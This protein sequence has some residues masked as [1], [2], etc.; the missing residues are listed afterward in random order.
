M[1]IHNNKARHA[2]EQALAYISKQ[3]TVFAD[4]DG[5]ACREVL[6]LTIRVPAKGDIAEPI[7]ILHSSG[8]F[9]YPPLEE[10]ERVMLTK[11]EIPGLYYTYGAR[12][13][14]HT[15]SNQI[16]DYLIPLLKDDPTSRR[17]TIV[18]YEPSK[19]AMIDRKDMPGMIMMNCNVK[20][21]MLDVTTIIRSNDVFFG[22]PA[23]VYQVSVLQDYIAKALKKK[24]GSIT[25]YSISA[26]VFE[27]QEDYINRLLKT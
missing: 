10:M 19:D 21:E 7:R 18:F 23:N 11:K 25:T 6:G 26:H 9:V 17:A 20:G 8:K 4:T 15:G 13:F 27:D 2:W 5:R 1:E 24:C 16:D 14:N 22:W 3:G 12:A